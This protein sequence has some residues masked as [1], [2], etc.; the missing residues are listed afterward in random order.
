M[1][2]PRQSARHSRR[3]LN[4]S[5][6]TT[7]GG[8]PLTRRQLLIGV[9]GVAGVA[10]VLAAGFEISEG[11]P[12]DTT[13]R[14]AVPNDAVFTTAE[15]EQIEDPASV[16]TERVTFHLPYGSQVFCNDGR[17]AVALT[18]TTTASPLVG[19]SLL[20]LEGGTETPVLAQ[21]IGA[22]EGFEVFDVRGV[23]NGLVWVEENIQDRR[24]RIYTAPLN[25]GMLDSTT[26]ALAAEGD[27]DWEIP[28]IAA[29]GRY[30]FWQVQ[31]TRTGALAKEDSV[32]YRVPFGADAASAEEL[33]RSSGHYACAISAGD[34]VV[35]IVPRSENAASSYEFVALS[36]TDGKAA[37]QLPL[38]ASMAPAD[39]AY[40]SNGFAF[41]F[42]AIYNYGG[43]LANL[44]TYV[45]A[46]A[47]AVGS[48][49]ADAYSDESWFRFDRA[50]TAAPA[51]CKDWFIVKS[52]SAV[53]AVDLNNRRYVAFDVPN[54][55]DTYGEYLASTGQ[56]DRFVT[57]ANVDYTPLEGDPVYEC[58]VHVWEPV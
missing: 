2:R 55:A 58:T 16:F 46:E 13:P 39:A 30:G 25:A 17:L 34:A 48:G 27:G 57:F 50:P 38:T 29:C 31:P 41:T 9:A 33:W 53:C 37:D 52:T 18:P 47:T 23:A 28:T 1:T 49:N 15:C 44:G 20:S 32:V 40:T 12:A 36:A 7:T 5:A 56:S 19:V 6:A 10:A 51:S 8:F 22:N 24:W 14:L 42:D 43:G 35:T 3:S 45:P 54:G 26:A 4:Q 21:A 11:A